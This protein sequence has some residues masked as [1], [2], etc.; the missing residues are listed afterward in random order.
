MKLTIACLIVSLFLISCATKKNTQ[1][2]A[3]ADDTEPS[4]T[5]AN[6]NNTQTTTASEEKANNHIVHVV[7][8][9]ESLSVIA[10]QYGISMQSIIELNN[11]KDPD[12]I[13][14]GQELLIPKLVTNF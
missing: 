6:S 11:I 10:Q 7:Q 8:E 12:L 14:I 9:G 2:T 5:M 13:R 1:A 3:Q 4:Q